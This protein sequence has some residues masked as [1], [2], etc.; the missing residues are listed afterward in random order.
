MLMRSEKKRWADVAKSHDLRS[1]DCSQFVTHLHSVQLK[2]EGEK[3]SEKLSD[4]SSNFHPHLAKLHSLP[5]VL[6][7]P[8]W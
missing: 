7:V 3:E 5:F 4:D 8:G 2:R 6:P 1:L